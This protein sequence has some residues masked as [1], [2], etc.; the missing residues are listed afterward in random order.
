[1]LTWG[2]PVTIWCQRTLEAQKYHLLKEGGYV[3]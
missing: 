1:V 3:N 2:S